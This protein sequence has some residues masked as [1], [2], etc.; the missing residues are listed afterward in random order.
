MEE[1]DLVDLYRI[2]SLKSISDEAESRL[3]SMIP[4]KERIRLRSISLQKLV[5]KDQNHPDIIPALLERLGPVRAALDDHGG[6][7]VIKKIDLE[8]NGGLSFI[9][10]LNGACIACGAAPSTL[11]G[12][13]YDLENDSEINAIY[14][15]DKL[16]E[17]FDDLSKEF[18]KSQTNICF[19]ST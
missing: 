6:G 19:K 18:L 13:K 10:T 17:S 15:E 12:I 2:E 16:L 9:L 14:F 5:L 11:V 7:I 8:N 3:N 1:D 4:M